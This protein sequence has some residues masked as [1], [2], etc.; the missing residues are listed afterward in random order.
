MKK[1][2]PSW[3][4][5][6]PIDTSKLTFDEVRNFKEADRLFTE[7]IPGP[8][9]WAYFIRCFR[10]LTAYAI[11]T[12]VENR[13]PS[14][15]KCWNEL[16]KFFMHEEV[17]DDEVF[18]QSWI[19]FDFPFGENGQTVLD[20]FEDFIMQGDVGGSFQYFIEQMRK[21]RLGLYQEILSSKKTTKFRELIT[22]NTIDTFRSVQEYEKGEIF[23]TRLVDYKGQ[24]YQ[25]G[26]PKCWPKEYK[27]QLEGFILE[28]MWFFDGSTT[29][30]KYMKLMKIG[31]PYWM[32]CVTSNPNFPIL[33]PDHYLEFLE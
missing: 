7:H 15:T 2:K 6:I 29:E 4:K 17:F 31:G 27:S 25:F 28:K 33:S 1:R 30:E 5:G 18:V 8:E 23:L 12:I 32:S 26:D 3:L 11:A 14:L 24:I 20:Y 22:G 21:T 16:D 9:G 10:F 13:F 19:F